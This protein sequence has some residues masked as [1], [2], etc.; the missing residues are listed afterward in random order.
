MKI[1]FGIMKKV[2]LGI[3]VVSTVTY[4]TSAFFIL[5]LKDFFKGIISDGLFM[6]ITFALGVFWTGFLGMLAARWFVKPLQQLMETSNQ[7]SEGHLNINV[8]PWRSNDELSVLSISFGKMVNQLRTIIDGIL[9]NYN[10]TDARVDELNAAI[11][12]ATNQIEHVT[13]RIEQISKGAEHQSHSAEA[14]FQSVAS[15]TR[16]T[17]EIN[18]QVHSARLLTNEMDQT[19]EES[20][21]VIQSLVNGMKRL[22]DLNRQSMEAVRRLDE[23]AAHIGEI[24]DVVGEIAERTH[25]LALNAS[26]EA[27]RAGEEGK[28][29]AVVADAVKKLAAQSAQSVED[30]RLLIGQIQ[31]EIKNVVNKISEQTKVAETESLQGEESVAALG[32]IACEADKV[33]EIVDSIARMV[34]A[35]TEQ[36][37]NV[38]TEARGV[39]EVA[40][41]T[42]SGAQEVLTLTRKQN[43]VM[44]EIAASSGLLKEHSI[45]LQEKIA[46]FKS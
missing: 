23:H 36:M 41:Q 9:E 11:E 30:I 19:I 46:F 32:N 39:A 38:L 43:A 1:K 24:S 45:M 4:G 2:V 28:G 35:R 44:E 16:A 27:A 7:V 3:T 13:N 14:M 21:G 34:A 20:A 31:I 26:I 10:V 17:E 40:A 25:L 15:E 6:L 5:V 18:K 42:K 12:Q 29:F 33:I 8:T 22:T 37:N